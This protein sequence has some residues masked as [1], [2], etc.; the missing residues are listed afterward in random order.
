MTFIQ[1]FGNALNLHMPCHVIVLEGVS[2]DRTNPGRKPRF[3]KG[4]PPSDADIAAVVQKISRRV[5]RT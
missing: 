5:I 1:R 2:L 3:L 4:A